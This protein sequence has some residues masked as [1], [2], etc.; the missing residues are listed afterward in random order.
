M[1]FC[2]MEKKS[3][4]IIVFSL[5]LIVG[6][7]LFFLNYR[8]SQ[9][10]FGPSEDQTLSEGYFK[11][12]LVNSFDESTLAHLDS[13]LSSV[14][15]VEKLSDTQFV[16]YYNGEEA[17]PGYIADFENINPEDKFE[18]RIDK[19]SPEDY[20]T[21]D[22]GSGDKV[23]FI[24]VRFYENRD[25]SDLLASLNLVPRQDYEHEYFF[26]IRPCDE[27]NLRAKVD[28]L[29]N[30]KEIESI[31]I[32][33]KFAIPLY[34]I[35]TRTGAYNIHAGATPYSEIYTGNERR[36][37]FWDAGRPRGHPDFENRI[38]VTQYGTFSGPIFE[39]SAQNHPTLVA[40][41]L[42]GSGNFWNQFSGSIPTIPYE[43]GVSP[44]SWGFSFDLLDAAGEM[45]WATDVYQLDVSSNSW[46]WVPLFAGGP[47]IL[48]GGPGTSGANPRIFYEARSSDRTA[49]LLEDT[50]I[51]F[52]A[53]NSRVNDPVLMFLGSICDPEGYYPETYQTSAFQRQVFNI[54]TTAIT[55]N[56]PQINSN[57][58]VSIGSQSGGTH[59]QW[60]YPNSNSY[61]TLNQNSALEIYY[62]YGTTMV[63]EWDCLYPPSSTKNVLTVGS[64]DLNG[65]TSDF[66]SRG[67]TWDGRVKPDVVSLGEGIITTDFTSSIGGSP[68]YT[69]SGV[70]GTSFAT[71]T[72][73][74]HA[75]L[76]K[77]MLEDKE[78]LENENYDGY[79]SALIKAAFIHTATD[80][81][82]PGP[83]FISG[84]GEINPQAAMNVL[85][86]NSFVLD[87]FNNN[88]KMEVKKYPISIPSWSQITTPLKITLVWNDYWNFESTFGVARDDLRELV[89]NLEVYLCDA[90]GSPIVRP[91][92]LDWQHPGQAATKGFNDRDNVEQVL[93]TPQEIQNYITTQ[94]QSL[95]ACVSFSNYYNTPEVNQKFVLMI[96]D[97][98]NGQYQY[99]CGNG[100]FEPQY[101]EECDKV[102][103]FWQWGGK[104]CADFGG[105]QAS[106][107][108][109]LRCDT[110][111]KIDGILCESPM[112]G[113]GNLGLGEMCDASDPE[114]DT[115]A[116]GCFGPGEGRGKACKCMCTNDDEC[117][118]PGRGE[119]RC[120]GGVCQGV[121]D[122]ELDVNE[123]CDPCAT[124]TVDVACSN[125]HGYMPA[126][127]LSWMCDEKG[128]CRDP[129]NMGA[130]GWWCPVGN[131]EIPNKPE[132]T[133]NR[134]CPPG[135]I[136]NNDCVCEANPKNLCVRGGVVKN[137][138]P[139]RV[140]CDDIK[141]CPDKRDYCDGNCQ[142]KRKPRP[143]DP[144]GSSLATNCG[145]GVVEGGWS[146]ATNPVEECERPGDTC[147]TTYINGG[148]VCVAGGVCS[149][150]CKCIGSASC[151]F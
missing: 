45:L 84:W 139:K 149:A 57:I 74:S 116:L 107:T 5:L 72:V 23:C 73:A 28:E 70:K 75:V 20:F 125:T 68:T 62:L 42:L 140:E 31:R 10:K 129:N 77:E 134:K 87:S 132:C 112:C 121:G 133:K 93:A 80:K 18:G 21:I 64:V 19:I 128:K 141:A 8:S 123:E 137:I 58:Q 143:A 48:H 2:I 50:P 95:F 41:V 101:G 26:E 99:T 37:G 146:W 11:F 15:L 32:T 60:I 147:F 103:H 97:G 52:A 130:D 108:S 55:I 47:G 144:I 145:N 4:F 17:L 16:G 150:N 113:N 91:F 6:L 90:S 122:C 94:T 3:D 102:Y 36:I 22:T 114:G 67:P 118:G 119:M 86:A 66:S 126:G 89:N 12:N 92:V 135:N 61:L 110:Q 29:A 44:D 14:R 63:D 127:G 76:L 138:H 65:V 40:G 106:G 151:Q 85:S 27:D 82:L 49:Y 13:P 39:L 115:C 148:P 79:K 104:T 71:P 43:I 9:V 100:Q 7:S 1:L 25:F 83:D 109:L 98:A 105:G 111:C 56:I 120:E 117:S 30:I 46:H 88:N 81:D 96:A 24:T 51:V 136:C 54:G 59:Y 33:P 34:N 38:K 124:T 78:E 53:G 69:T 131:K 142:C 35:G